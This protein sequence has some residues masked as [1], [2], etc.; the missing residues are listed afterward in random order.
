M[1]EEL[2][3][4]KVDPSQQQHLFSC[5]GYHLRWC[6]SAVSLLPCCVPYLSLDCLPVNLN[7]S[8]CKLYSNGAFA[9][10]VKLIASESRQEVTLAYSRVSN[11]HNYKRETTSESDSRCTPSID[12][13]PQWTHSFS[14][15]N[16]EGK[17]IAK[18]PLLSRVCRPSPEISREPELPRSPA[19]WTDFRLDF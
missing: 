6:Y 2:E 13:H 12:N 16:Q 19:C 17:R 8:C 10:Q 14:R 9:L 5:T 7:A 15:T 4:P 3:G 11:K 1:F 18:P